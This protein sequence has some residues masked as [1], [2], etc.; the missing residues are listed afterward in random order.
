[1][2]L[3]LFLKCVS[4]TIL[5]LFWENTAHCVI[6]P[7]IVRVLNE[8][9]IANPAELRTSTKAGRVGRL[10]RQTK[11]PFT[12][13]LEC[14]NPERLLSDRPLINMNPADWVTESATY[15]VDR[16]EPASGSVFV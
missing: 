6:I 12:R 5:A 9:S 10:V 16:F 15:R 13:S 14:L 3:K 8:N 11:G 4:L 2:N 7:C 1:M